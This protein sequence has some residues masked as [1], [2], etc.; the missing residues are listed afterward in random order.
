MSTN[1]INTDITGIWAN[2]HFGCGW[3]ARGSLAARARLERN[4]QWWPATVRFFPGLDLTVAISAGSYDT[5]DQWVPP[6]RVIPE[7]GLPD[8]S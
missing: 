8:I 1:S 7:V 2:S 5:P 3:A 6:T 4:R